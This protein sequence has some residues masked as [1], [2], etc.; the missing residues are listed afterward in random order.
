MKWRRVPLRA[1]E[2]WQ[3]KTA[4][5]TRSMSAVSLRQ[6][7]YAGF[8]ER[9]GKLWDLIKLIGNG[10]ITHEVEVTDTPGMVAAI[11]E[12]CRRW[13]ARPSFNPTSL[14]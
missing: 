12:V 9:A 14:R 3:D 10:L 8:F 4:W 13:L 2:P 6:C 7:L 1:A 5:A 11:D